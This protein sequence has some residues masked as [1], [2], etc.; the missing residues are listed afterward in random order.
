MTPPDNTPAIVH[1]IRILHRELYVIGKR[2]PKSDKL[3]IHATTET[4][5]LRMLALSVDA[6]F[7]PKAEKT[8]TL[9]TLRLATEIA[10]HLWRTERELNVID[11]KTYIRL[12]ASFVGI[13]K[14]AN[15]WLA[16][17]TKKEP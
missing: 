16:Y 1:A 15:G 3:G 9:K 5:A 12:A 2:L 6:S 17:V 7:R 8:E 14:M 13:S 10:K 4:A 11:E